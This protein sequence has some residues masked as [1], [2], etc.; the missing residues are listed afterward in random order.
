MM[1]LVAAKRESIDLHGMTVDEAIPAVDGFLHAAYRAGLRR[2]WIIH[3]KGSGT[4]RRA[5]R[6]HLAGHVLVLSCTTADPNR[7]G[8]G[9]TQVEMKD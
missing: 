7:G 3:G 8:Q 2:V 9:V 4:L 1:N 6:R 5:I